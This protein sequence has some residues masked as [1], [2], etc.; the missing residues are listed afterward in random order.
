MPNFGPKFVPF[1]TTALNQKANWFMTR[2]HMSGIVMQM[3]S[4]HYRLPNKVIWLCY[5]ATNFMR[6][7]GCDLLT[8]FLQIHNF[9]THVTIT[10]NQ[11]PLYP[12]HRIVIVIR[13]MITCF[14][15][16]KWVFGFTFSTQ[17]FLKMRRK[18]TRYTQVVTTFL[19]CKKIY[20]SNYLP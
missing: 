17:F 7:D 9:H 16:I 8:C 4:P 12:V 15:T 5:V 3:Q 20:V 10:F 13:K 6:M 1:L 14:S 2:P 19:D 18:V 11:V